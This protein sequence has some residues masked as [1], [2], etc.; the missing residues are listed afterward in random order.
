[1]KSSKSKASALTLLKGGVSAVALT[2]MAATLMTPA[3]AQDAAPTSDGA[4]DAKEIVV[5][6][7]RRSLK[8]AQQI[9]RDA[10]TVVDSITA[11]DIGA[12]PDK[13]VAEALQ[14][15][16]GITVSR[17]AAATDTAHYS[18]EPSGV[19][20]RGLSQ[21]RSEFNGRDVFSANSSR[22]LS[23]G[24]ISPELMSGV[25]TYKNQTADLI[26]GGIAGSI[27]LRTRVPFDSK[28]RLLAISAD[29]SYGDLAKKW[30]PD[31]SGIYSDRWDTELG[32][33]GVMLNYAYSKVATTS[34]GIQLG[35]MGI[36][37]TGGQTGG[38]RDL[39]GDNQFDT[40]NT[41]ST[42]NFAYIP[43]STTY[44]DN[45]FDRTRNGVAFAAQ[46]QNHDH[47]MLATLQ[48]NDSKYENEWHEHTAGTTYFDVWAQ[49]LGY[50]FSNN[51]AVDATA[52]DTFND[53]GLFQTG[54]LT[55][56][57]GWFGGSDTQAENNA[58]GWGGS[59]SQYAVNSSGQNMFNSCQ[60]G[61]A[62]QCG[63]NPRQ[64]AG[65]G[66]ATRY[67]NGQEST[68]D[69]SFNFKWDINEHLKTNFD[70]QYVQAD[71]HDYDLEVDINSYAN[72]GLDLSGKYPVTT[73]LDPINVNQSAG[74]LSNPNN[75][76]YNSV[77]DHSE[78]SKGH[79]F[80]TKLDLEYD[81][82]N[83]GWLDSIKA[84]VRYADREQNVN[85]STY[86]W[87][88]ISNTY[89]TNAGSF[90]IDQ[91]SPITWYTGDNPVLT[92]P[93]SYVEHN[94]KG[95]QDG[96]YSV[97]SFGTDLL[98][99]QHL[100][101]QNNFV[102]F[103]YDIMENRAA[104]AKAMG[105][106]PDQAG[107]GSWVPICERTNEVEGS[108]YTPAEIMDI[109]EETEAAF[110]ELKFGGH[111][112][113]LLGFPVSGNVG[114]R[115]VQTT[116]TSTGG[117]VLYPTAFEYNNNNC[118]GALTQHEIDLAN[119]LGQLPVFAP[120]IVNH[121]AEDVAFRDGAI[122]SDPQ[123]PSVVEST[124]INWLPSFNIKVK[125]NDEWLVRFAASR[126][127]SRP[128]MGYLRNYFFIQ[129]SAL[130]QTELTP[131]NPNIVYG[132]GVVAGSNPA[133][134]CSV[135]V[136]C[137][138]N[139]FRY[140]ASSGNPRL[141]STTADQFDI[142]A[143]RYFGSVG[144][145]TFNLFYKKFHDYIQ[146]GTRQVVT[147]TH[148]SARSYDAAGN[149]LFEADGTTPLMHAVTRDIQV[150][151]PVNGEGAS[152]KGFEVAYQRFF[153]FLPS[154]FDG[155]GI[156][157]NYTKIKNTGVKNTGLGSTSAGGAGLGS[158]GGGVISQ[159]DNIQV[160]TLEGLSDDAYN[161]VGMYEK[162]SWALR[163]AYN[164]RSKYLVTA[165]DCCVGF[166]I[167]QKGAGYLDASVR[168]K[169]ND[170][171]ELS[172]QGSNL[173]NTDTVLMQQVDNRGTLMPNAWF[174]NDRR[175]QI[176]VRLKY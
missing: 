132:T 164:W 89:S 20:V 148:G 76:Y 144:S 55:S 80:A 21:V 135:G 125:L 99:G 173:L 116:D 150:T 15:V 62:F 45:N 85:W 126:A 59:A 42:H 140:T 137:S 129:G 34:Q 112:K 157:A 171:V 57:H 64:G 175:V 40:Q 100:I 101:D 154:P 172:V 96:L 54:L 4:A 82:D 136:A 103:N 134:N 44:R 14:R 52:G 30:T 74:F 128:D 91:T 176:G 119:E 81:F 156:Q 163:A 61:A 46:W 155:L 47:T 41:D 2:A 1:M 87:K 84:G 43:V 139:G 66:T 93:A 110:V 142:T 127:M 147:L 106:A 124:H 123:F 25:D 28:G 97:Q 35:R 78:D 115:W 75:Y 120:C 8:T 3:F 24:D 153:D 26:E 11:T 138:Y 49:P 79:E 5:V 131:D 31:F 161:V 48:Y 107:V 104:M 60:A 37:C 152:I 133:T 83:D 141:K 33:F 13:S 39:C 160:H 130:S 51:T 151:G 9:K 88:N 98:H 170:N 56:N 70:I 162:G 53:Q 72:V 16:A 12:F 65:F 167:W 108:C 36:F 95:Y 159:Y 63:A 111:D 121:S 22:G 32:E 174:E 117:G 58:L 77:S 109:D 166:P 169:V 146:N 19:L 158:G 17:F 143:E 6:G 114:M 168:Y 145:F 118:D 122:A 27:N 165:A 23:W 94:F 113:T 7:V 71:V 50:Q 92:N 73:L 10:D 86:N 68:R 69:L 38:D 90:N 102:Y 149:A 18:A 105:M 67:N 29:A